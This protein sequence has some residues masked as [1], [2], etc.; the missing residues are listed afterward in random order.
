M[1]LEIPATAMATTVTVTAMDMAT[2]LAAN[3]VLTANTVPAAN[4]A[5]RLGR[6]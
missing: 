1:V 3:M 6:E 5:L 4:T 2:V